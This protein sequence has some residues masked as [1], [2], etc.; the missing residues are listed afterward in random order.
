MLGDG[1]PGLV[2]RVVPPGEVGAPLLK[3]LW[4]PD[5]NEFCSGKKE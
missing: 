2:N 5:K 4:I 1:P 3:N